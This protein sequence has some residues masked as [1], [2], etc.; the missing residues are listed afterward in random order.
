MSRQRRRTEGPGGALQRR[1]VQGCGRGLSRPRVFV[2]HLTALSPVWTQHTT[3]LNI[4]ASRQQQKPC[5]QVTKPWHTT[6]LLG[7]TGRPLG[8]APAREQ[9]AE[10]GRGSRAH[11]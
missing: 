3:V 6:G 11:S 8:W 9:R 4:P 1:G 2:S 5:I 7:T 10:E